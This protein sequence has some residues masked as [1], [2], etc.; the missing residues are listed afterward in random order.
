VR[1]LLWNLVAIFTLL[2]AACGNSLPIET[3][4]KETVASFSYTTQHDEPFGLEDL[5]D[6]WWIADFIFTNCETVC[7]PMTSN[8]AQLQENILSEGLDVHLVSF[9]VD[10]DYDTP[11]VLKEYGDEYGADYDSWTFL[12]GYSFQEIKELSVKSF[13]APLKEPERGSDQ[14]MH[15]T[16]FFLVDPNGKIV[17]GYDGVPVDTIDEIIDDLLVLQNDDLL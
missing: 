14:V 2:L 17:K 15:D 3:N 6:K 5:E 12:T 11:E 1:K 13:R 9:S 16:R 10:P 7:L 4:M 8:M